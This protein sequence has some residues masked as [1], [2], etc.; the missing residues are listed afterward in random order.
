MNTEIIEETEQRSETVYKQSVILF[1]DDV[2]D[3]DH[4]EDCLMKICFKNR[5]EAEK[6]AK[7]AHNKGRAI[8]YVASLEECETVA[9][10]MSEQGLTVSIQ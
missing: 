4:V 5:K 9:E 3:F 2:N 10:K 7:E 6:I 1:N 8:C